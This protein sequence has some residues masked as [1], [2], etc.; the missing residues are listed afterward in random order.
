[1]L[2]I[3]TMQKPIYTSATIIEIQPMCVD[4]P[5]YKLMIAPDTP[6]HTWTAGQFVM[7][8]LPS[9]TASSFARPFSIASQDTATITLYIH[10]RGK[11]TQRLRKLNVGDTVHLWGPLGTSYTSPSI[12]TL[13]IAGGIG[14]APFVTYTHQ[15]QENMTLLFGHRLDKAHYPLDSFPSSITIHSFHDNDE[16]SLQV[17]LRAIEHAMLEHEQGKILACG[18]LPLL[19]Y[20]RSLALQHN[21]YAELS[22]EEHMFCGVGACLGCVCKTTHAYPQE[23]Y[24]DSYVQ[25]CTQGP[26]FTAHT[27]VI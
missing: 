22:I 12:S 4:S 18:P 16:H 15:Y 27:V 8:R 25:S 2:S 9:D 23:R 1:M 14:I 24:R 26:V 13:L 5:I 3:Y 20:V 7:L 6:L 21:L 17:F 19:R 10:I 11:E